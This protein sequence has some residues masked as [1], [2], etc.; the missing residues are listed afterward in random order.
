VLHA[1]SVTIGADSHSLLSAIDQ[2]VCPARQTS[3]MSYA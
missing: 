2:I 3:G 1:I